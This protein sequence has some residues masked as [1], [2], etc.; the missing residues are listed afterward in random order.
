MHLLRV[1]VPERVGVAGEARGSPL[2]Q[3]PRFSGFTPSA[4]VVPNLKLKP[5]ALNPKSPKLEALGAGC[6]SQWST[7]A[8]LEL[9]LD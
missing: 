2:W 1:S 3:S 4:L 6:A 5:Y 9:A 8:G 7:S